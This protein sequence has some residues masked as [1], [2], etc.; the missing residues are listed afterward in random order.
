M[1]RRWEVRITQPGHTQEMAVDGP[2]YRF[3]TRLVHDDRK[4][5]ARFVQSQL[6]YAQLE[7]RRLSTPGR[8]RW[9]DR[10]RR[11]G[12]MP[13]VAGCAG[14]AMA[15]GPMCGA[16]SLRYGCERALFECLLALELLN[17]RH[18]QNLR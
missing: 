11:T 10:L 17:Q 12:L 8:R 13:F 6:A 18:G 14:Y 5:L 15:G 9:Q 3:E 16:A 4:S 2:T 7:A 1:F